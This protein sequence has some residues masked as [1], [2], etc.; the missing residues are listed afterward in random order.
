MDDNAVF[1]EVLHDGSK[2][3]PTMVLQNGSGRTPV[4]TIVENPRGNDREEPP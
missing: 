3:V 1:M 4:G 2:A